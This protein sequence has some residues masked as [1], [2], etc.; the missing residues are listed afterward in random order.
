MKKSA[1][2]FLLL[3]LALCCTLAVG[4]LI[5]GPAAPGANEILSPA[6]VLIQ[7]DGSINSAILADLSDYFS[8]RFY[9]RQAL[10]TA[11]AR[12]FGASVSDDVIEGSNGW[13]YFASTLA[14]YTGTDP[15]TERELYSAGQNLQLIQDA[16]QE[17]GASF[18]F[19]CVPN[20]NTLYPEHMP[21][22]GVVN[23][24]HDLD[25]LYSLL[26]QL[27]VAHLDIRPEF[28]DEVLY[29]AHDSHWNSRG[30]ALGADLLNAALGRES[31][32]FA[33]SFAASEPH[34]GDLYE[35]LFPAGQDSET[36]PVFSGSLTFQFA[37]GSGAKPDSITIRTES[38]A[39]SSL[40][41]YRDSFGNLLF[42]YLADSFESAVFSRATAYN[43]A[44]AE[45]QHIVIELVERNLPYLIRYVPIL[46]APLCDLILPEPHDTVQ[47]SGSTAGPTFPEHTIWKGAAPNADADSPVYLLTNDGI[48][49]CFLMENDG[50]AAYLPE[51]LEISAAAWYINGTLT[52]FSATE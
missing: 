41:M 33:D 46:E 27:H 21:Y 48:F 31:Q 23:S 2:L 24:L 37:A 14:D 32:Y 10:I 6:P 35:M 12:L 1:F 30:A 51:G 9:P 20:K 50:F 40:L 45:A 15:M 52:A 44:D 7:K 22:L 16:C 42:P 13:L 47:L 4:F 29:F 38:D 11:Y 5:H 3:G 34:C 28:T 17:K 26:D 19:L 43:I 49:R 8:D 18:T 39:D 36:N 25:R